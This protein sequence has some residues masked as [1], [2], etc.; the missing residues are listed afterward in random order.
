[1]PRSTLKISRVMLVDDHPLVRKGLA[2]LISDEPYLEVCGQ[3]E[4][5]ESALKILDDCRPDL[6]IVD[7]T[8][9]GI[10]GV[11]LIKRIRSRNAQV[12]ILVSSMHEESLFAERCLRAGANGYIDKASATDEVLSAV[13]KV[14]DGQLYLSADMTSRMLHGAIRGQAE[15]QSCLETLTD[16]ELE[17]FAL[18]GKGLPTRDI[19]ERL[20]LSVK[21][22][23][24]HRDHVRRKLGIANSTELM[25]HAVQWVL[26]N[27]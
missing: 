7:I 25:R 10:N 27:G 19:A 13:T 17:V 2:A 16:R 20:H 26:E 14:L 1:M 11:D 4:S 9:P 15:K 23:E 8:L 18:I 12:R 3:A 5:A 21:T 6:M 22:I 24:T